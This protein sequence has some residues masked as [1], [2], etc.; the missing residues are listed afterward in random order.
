MILEFELDGKMGKI[1]K[2]FTFGSHQQSQYKFYYNCEDRTRGGTTETLKEIESVLGGS[3]NALASSFQLQGGESGGFIGGT[4]AARKKLLA[5][6]MSLGSFEGLEY[7]VTRDISATRGEIKSLDGQFHGVALETIDLELQRMRDEKCEI[8]ASAESITG[9]CEIARGVCVEASFRVGSATN[10]LA[11]AKEA[12]IG[13]IRPSPQY[14][15]S[16]ADIE[17]LKDKLESAKTKIAK[18]IKK[19]ETFVPPIDDTP[20][21]ATIAQFKQAESNL[22]HSNDKMQI[23]QDRLLEVRAAIAA[24]VATATTATA[25]DT[26][27]ESLLRKNI[28]DVNGILA[29]LAAA[30]VTTAAATTAAGAAA[31]AATTAP[32]TATAA[33]TTAPTATL[34]KAQKSYDIK[35]KWLTASTHSATIANH[36]HYNDD[37]VSCA[38]TKKIFTRLTTGDAKS[39]LV[40]AAKTYV[41]LLKARLNEVITLRELRA[42]EAVLLG[43][44]NTVKEIIKC[45]EEQLNISR[46]NMRGYTPESAQKAKI[47]RYNLIAA[48]EDARKVRELSIA[49]LQQFIANSEQEIVIAMNADHAALVYDNLDAAEKNLNDAICELKLATTTADLM[50]DNLNKLT[51]QISVID[52]D[53]LRTAIEREYEAERMERYVRANK[54]QVILKAYRTVLKPVGGIGDRLLE[55]GRNLLE[56][57]IN[58]A[59][60]ELGAKFRISIAQDYDIAI[61][62]VAALNDTMTG[63]IASMGATAPMSMNVHDKSVPST[64][65]SGYQKFVLSLAA[66]LA[67]WRLSTSPRPDAF[68]IDEGFGACDEEN[69][70]SMA[71]ALE[72]LASAPGG[73]QLVFIVSHVDTLKTRLERFLE[74]EVLASG[75]KVSNTIQEHIVKRSV[76]SN[77]QIASDVIGPDPEK[78]GNVY[79]QSCKQSLTIGRLSKHLTTQKHTESLK[80]LRKLQMDDSA[81]AVE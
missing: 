35:Q 37:C 36:L 56:Q 25:A 17:L 53:I 31:P 50:N 69:L 28:Q 34:E 54:Q 79:C 46:A 75:S 12:V 45:N 10:A 60:Y 21:E 76:A 67:I 81:A 23:I 41:E 43:E 68:I 62:N 73:P 6:V 11:A 7:V 15:R 52:Q 30:A 26:P 32:T 33:T 13:Y 63:V 72:S 65:A 8:A 22:L 49:K 57:K 38:N 59:L 4:P 74:I 9:E 39:E 44:I 20:S 61:L 48:A 78:I 71:S 64:L 42:K 16:S 58:D 3:I 70:E 5:N 14:N 55:K 66:R 77:A 40:T 29:T 27:D 24:A 19:N 18:L 47:E 80:R 2:A 51:A 1:E